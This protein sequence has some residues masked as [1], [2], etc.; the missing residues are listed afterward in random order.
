MYRNFLK[1][2]FDIIISI[3]FLPIFIL[4]AIP[5][6][7][8]IKLESKGP[9]FFKQKRA[10]KNGTYFEILKFRSMSSSPDDE[11]KEFEPGEKKRIT[12]VGAILRK[13]KL[14]EIPQIINVIKGEMSIVGPRPEVKKYVDVY[15]EEWEKILSI[16]PGITDPASVK[17]RNEEELLSKSS[18]P[19][20]EYKENI[21]P[22]KLK[23]YEEYISNITFINDLKIIFKTIFTVFFK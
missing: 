6:A 23:L 2:I 3:A 7:I 5:I 19:E 1:R 18:D 20:R 22:K 16:K 15:P 17:F 14:D 13:T 21:L 4:L 9:V 12:K 8:F 10:G 11:K